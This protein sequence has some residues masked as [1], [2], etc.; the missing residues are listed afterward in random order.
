MALRLPPPSVSVGAR[1]RWGGIGST[2]C[3]NQFTSLFRVQ[4]RIWG[5]DAPNVY[6]R[7]KK[8]EGKY[9]INIKLLY[10]LD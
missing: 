4:G 3:I 5:D 9:Y 1:F 2:V 10:P 6:K 7:K 8:E